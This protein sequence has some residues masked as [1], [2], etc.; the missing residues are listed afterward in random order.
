M[1]VISESIELKPTGLEFINAG[2]ASFN[3]DTKSCFL[4]YA[5]LTWYIEG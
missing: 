4:L 5:Q 1:N 2:N 3:G